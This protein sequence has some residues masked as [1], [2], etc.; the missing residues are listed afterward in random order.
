MLK[1]SNYSELNHSVGPSATFSV[2]KVSVYKVSNYSELN[3]SVGEVRLSTYQEHGYLT[4]SNY[5]ELNHSVGTIK[6]RRRIW[7]V[8]PS[9]QLFRIKPFGWATVWRLTLTA[10]GSVSNYSE[11]NHS[12]GFRQQLFRLIRLALIIVSATQA[13]WPAS[14]VRCHPCG[15]GL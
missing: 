9:F 14:S 10:P 15:T 1:V 8:P 12:V 2:Y 4:V 13:E 11:L 7:M 6:T 3:H 5:S